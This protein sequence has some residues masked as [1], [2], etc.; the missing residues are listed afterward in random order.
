MNRITF[1]IVH[2]V[3]VALMT[4][5][6]GLVFGNVVLR[7]VFNTGIAFSEEASRFL[8]MWLTLLGAL[9]VM[10][11]RAH[12]GMN[13]VVARLSPGG[14]RLCRLLADAAALGCCLLL[15]HGAWQIVQIGMDDRAPVTGV[16]LGLV[17]A[18]LLL[19]GAGMTAM[20]A[21]SLGR[22]LSG[23]MT[24]GELTPQSGPSGE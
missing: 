14:Q 6:I 20:L 18:C 24:L 5:M 15:T 11:D 13:T 2:G 1:R 7:Y 3:M 12:L 10:H 4:A 21:W 16:P 17:Y 22:L 9:L 19:C 23:R 8:F